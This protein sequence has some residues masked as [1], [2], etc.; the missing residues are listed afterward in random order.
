M[1][2]IKHVEMKEKI[3]KE[4]LRR[5]RKLL[6]TKLCS[7]NLIKGINTWTALL[8]RYS[9]PFLKWTKQELQQMH[10]RTRK[11]MIMHKALYPREDIE[12][13]YA[14][15]KEGGRVLKIALIRPLEDCI[16]KYKER[17]VTVTRNNIDN[18]CINGTKIT[19]KMGRIITSYIF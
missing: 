19:R 8:E 14:S 16:K 18:R 13:I 7:G 4:Y 15:K 10:L 9:K 3:K 2:N 12:W 1:D 17:L 5:T 11:L 6:D